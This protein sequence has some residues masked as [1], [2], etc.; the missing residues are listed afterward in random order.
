MCKEIRKSILS[1]YV[2]QH[3][4]ILV[5]KVKPL[6]WVCTPLT[7]CRRSSKRINSTTH[8]IARLSIGSIEFKRIQ[9]SSSKRMWKCYQNSMTNKASRIS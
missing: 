1:F 6:G 8:S 4:E 5:N 2:Y 3:N 7:S 9:S